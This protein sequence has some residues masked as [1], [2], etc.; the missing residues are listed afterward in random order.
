MDLS[1]DDITVMIFR[2]SATDDLG[3]FSLNRQ[4]LNI[5]MGL[6]G[7]ITVGEL[8]AELGLNLVTMRELIAKLLNLGLIENVQKEIVALDGDFFRCLINQLSLATGPIASILIEDEVHHLG[9]QVDQ[10]PGHRALKLVEGLAA[11]IR[12]EDKKSLFLKNMI[13]KIRQKGYLS[14]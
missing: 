3:N 9:Y 7:E 4:T 10:F 14:P 6:N 8:A 12:R 2:R 11:E 13:N 5:Y 1:S